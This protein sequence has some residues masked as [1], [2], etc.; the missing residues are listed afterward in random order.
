VILRSELK[1]SHHAVGSLLPG[2]LWFP[3]CRLPFD[4]LAMISNLQCNALV[5]PTC[6]IVLSAWRWTPFP[7]SGGLQH[8][9]GPS[10]CSIYPVVAIG[11]TLALYCPGRGSLFPYADNGP[12]IDA[13]NSN[14][15]PYLGLQ[16][17]N[18]TGRRP[19]FP[20]LG[21]M[22]LV[23]S[24]GGCQFAMNPHYSRLSH[25]RSLLGMASRDPGWVTGRA[26]S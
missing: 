8:L 17:V 12:P 23:G 3:L 6:F 21:C 25:S 22:P 16:S 24:P 11:N 19:A 2:F 1:E 14:W 26:G 10:N 18:L 4:H 20:L 9:C 7:L 13:W 15:L 5:D